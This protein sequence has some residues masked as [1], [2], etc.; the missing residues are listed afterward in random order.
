MD[1]LCSFLFQKQREFLNSR[2]KIWEEDNYGFW[3]FKKRV[4]QKG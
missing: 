1:A 2:K 4:I 3:F